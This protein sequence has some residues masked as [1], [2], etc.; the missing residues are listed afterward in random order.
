MHGE[1]PRRNLKPH[2]EHTCGIEPKAQAIARRKHTETNRNS[3]A[4][5][6]PSVT[7]KP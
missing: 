2:I 7:R 4:G 6:D 5:F 3:P 1:P